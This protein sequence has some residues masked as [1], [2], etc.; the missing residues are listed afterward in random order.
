MI[1]RI[2]NDDDRIKLHTVAVS[3]KQR[4]D[5]G[6][7]IKLPRIVT[8][9]EQIF[10]FAR[11]TWRCVSRNDTTSTRPF[12]TFERWIWCK[13]KFA[14]NLPTCKISSLSQYRKENKAPAVLRSKAVRTMLSKRNNTTNS[15]LARRG[16]CSF[17]QT[18]NMYGDGERE[19]F[20]FF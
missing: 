5:A 10:D 6:L 7:K 12:D 4:V 1:I 15:V 19:T 3:H 8:I 2:H 11:Q 9:N 16:T 14:T 13:H 18:T 20:G 17:E